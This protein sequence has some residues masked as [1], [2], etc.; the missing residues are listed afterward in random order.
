MPKCKRCAFF[1]NGICTQPTIANDLC[2]NAQ[3]QK[4]NIKDLFKLIKVVKKINKKFK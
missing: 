3:N 1:K 4:T 2:Y